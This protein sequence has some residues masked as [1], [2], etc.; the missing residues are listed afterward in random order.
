[1]PI[2]IR[3][4]ISVATN[5]R[6]A[7]Q[8]YFYFLGRVRAMA[9]SIPGF[10]LSSYPQTAT[11]SPVII[12]ME[13]FKFLQTAIYNV[14]YI[15]DESRFPKEPI[16]KSL[17]VKV[18]D[19]S[20]ILDRDD[21]INGLKTF[22][23]DD[24]IFIANTK[25][26]LKSTETAI[27]ILN[28]FFYVVAFIVIILCFFLLFVSFTTNVNE[29]AWEFGVLR[30]IGMTSFQVIRVYIYEAMSIVLASV[31]IGFIIGDMVSV[32][33]SLQA[34]LFSELPF[35]FDFPTILFFSVFGMSVAVAILGSYLPAR[36]LQKKRIASALKN[37]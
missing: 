5:G 1:M 3:A 9:S 21:V 22:I 26:I 25:D 2:E 24:L 35:T 33:L 34:C 8:P 7:I 19:S 17:F 31:M 15:E 6:Y 10:L 23:K 27:L 11:F 16:M 32:T 18:D 20:S 37:L 29:N 13:Q 14:S 36:V 28:V 4:A 30:A 12:S